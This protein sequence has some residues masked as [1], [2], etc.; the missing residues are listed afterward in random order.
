MAGFASLA[1]VGE[2]YGQQIVNTF[3]Y[4]SEDYSMG[5]QD[6][7]RDALKFADDFL[8]N[9]QSEYLSVHNANYTLLRAEVTLRNNAFEPLHGAPAVR[10]ISAHGTDTGI[11]ED[12]TT[13]SSVTAILGF[14]LGPQHQISGIG[15]AKKNVGYVAIGPV[16]EAQV[17]NYGHLAAGYQ[18]NLSAFGA[19]VDDELIDVV[20]AATFTPVRIHEKW[21]AATLITPR[22]LEW[23][24]YSD[25]LGYRIKQVAS[26]RRSRMPEE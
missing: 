6:P 12:Q 7:F 11:G 15:N 23:R 19:K 5:N 25:V 13:G 22:I 2:H 8:A 18:A 17:D 10:T 20:L 14:M 26:W 21:I 4:R 1:L 24:T 9:C 3:T 16:P